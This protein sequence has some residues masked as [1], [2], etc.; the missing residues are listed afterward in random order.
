[1]EIFESKKMKKIE[2]IVKKLPSIK[3]LQLTAACK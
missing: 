1:M 3:K 2:A